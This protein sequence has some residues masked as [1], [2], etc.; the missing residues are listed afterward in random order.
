MDIQGPAWAQ[1]T[2]MKLEVR[3]VLYSHQQGTKCLH[4]AA[5]DDCNKEVSVLELGPHPALHSGKRPRIAP[6]LQ[7]DRPHQA[8]K[9]ELRSE[10]NCESGAEATMKPSP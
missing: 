2:H 6:S 4:L 10:I 5:Q 8:T 7:G 9:C 3:T 1:V